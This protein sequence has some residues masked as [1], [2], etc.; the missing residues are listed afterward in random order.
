MVEMQALAKKRLQ[1][2][3]VLFPARKE[4]TLAVVII[5]DCFALLYDIAFPICITFIGF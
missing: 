2:L 4:I 1:N 3:L 5:I